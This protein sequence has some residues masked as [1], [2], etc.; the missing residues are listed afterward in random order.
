MKTTDRPN[1]RFLDGRIDEARRLLAAGGSDAFIVTHLPNI[2]YLC[3]FTGSNGVLLVLS[4]S[5]H[6]FTDSRYTLQ[7][8]QEVVGAHVHI[9]KRSLLD[10][11]GDFLRVR[12]KKRGLRV[13]FE[14]AHLS[15]AQWAPLKKAAGPRARWSSVRS[16][17]AG[18]VEGM[19]EI[20]S[21]DELAVMRDAAKL[22]SEVMA[23]VLQLVR[24]GVSELELAAEVDY[25]MRR[26]GA[27]G[28]SFETIVA[29]GRRTALPHARP[30]QKR[31]RKNELVLLDL[32]AILRHYC[33][34]LTRTV[35]LGRAPAKIRQWYQAVD[36]A[37]AAA[38]AV[39]GAGVTAGKVVGR[40]GGYWTAIKS[41]GTS[42]TAPVTDWE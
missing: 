41:G 19:R 10:D 7:A 42:L 4:E 37:Q 23:E 6:L 26:K 5:A 22:G 3:G 17:S 13:A 28:P 33:S 31:L 29:S 21:A 14:P 24:P 1:Q 2:F 20:K 15:V 16:H 27:S 38:L 30:T 12:A 11:S 32:G 8:R 34:D 39:I 35:Y 25:R 18:L 40:R 9:S 36:E